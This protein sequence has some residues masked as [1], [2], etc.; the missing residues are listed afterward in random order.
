SRRA[1]PARL[2]IACAIALGT[3]GVMAGPAIA[4]GGFLA[5]VQDRYEAGDRVT[6]VAYVGE[7]VGEGGLG[8][9]GDG[10]FFAYLR[11]IDATPTIR[12]QLQ[13]APFTPLERDLPVGRL[14]VTPTGSP[15]YL[16]YRVSISFDLPAM[17]PAGRYSLIYC[18]ATCSKGLDDLI[19]GLI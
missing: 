9:V 14:S 18:N 16:A 17:L 8:R 3:L 15:G 7:G 13:M 12:N 5:P 1:T 4:G 6:L 2:L 11:A 10:P 19:G